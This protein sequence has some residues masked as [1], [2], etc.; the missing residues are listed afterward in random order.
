MHTITQTRTHK[1]V[2]NFA[3]ME[4]T[5]SRLCDTIDR[6]FG[7]P[8]LRC[9]SGFSSNRLKLVCGQMKW[10]FLIYGYFLFLL[11]LVWSM[12]MCFG[13][14]MCVYVYAFCSGLR[15][16]FFFV[17]RLSFTF[18]HLISFRWSAAATITIN[19][20]TTQ[21]NIYIW[22]SYTELPLMSSSEYDEIT[23]S[24]RKRFVEPLQCDD[25]EEPTNYRC[26]F[27]IVIF[28]WIFFPL[29]FSFYFI[30][31]AN[32]ISSDRDRK[33][34]TQIKEVTQNIQ[35]TRR[36]SKQKQKKNYPKMVFLIW[37]CILTIRYGF[38]WMLIALADRLVC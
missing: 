36:R 33:K 31:N 24:V 16:F 20:V 11:H 19:I 10:S 30:F 32:G 7:T 23:H 34:N 13:I 37:M 21:M 2:R 15:L 3:R 18:I 14:S 9:A 29:I 6:C 38:C 17:N 1:I 12:S 8:T 28:F 22:Q 25:C 35:K 27:I 26:M 4:T 5:E